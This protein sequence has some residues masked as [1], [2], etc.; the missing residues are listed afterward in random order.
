MT[1]RSASSALF[2]NWS[3]E[4]CAT[5]SYPISEPPKPSTV[6]S[7]SVLPSWRFSIAPPLAA[8]YGR[9]KL[10]DSDSLRLHQTRLTRAA[11]DVA[12]YFCVQ[13]RHGTFRVT[14]GNDCDHA[15]THVKYLVHLR[16]FD[17]SIL[18]QNF[19]DPGHSP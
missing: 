9:R 8:V 10:S 3:T 4:S 2:N 1:F 12:D 18:L 7:I 17:V 11:I 15:D 14:C 16:P 5:L 19:E 13:D 6:T